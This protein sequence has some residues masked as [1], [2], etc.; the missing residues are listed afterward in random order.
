MA[1]QKALQDLKAPSWQQRLAAARSLVASAGADDLP[2]LLEARATETAKFVQDVL[3]G[4]LRRINR[5]VD[6]ARGSE[7]EE[8]P[9]ALVRQLNSKAIEEVTRTFLHEIEPIVGQ[10]F[11]AASAEVPSFAHSRTKAMLGLL[12]QQLEA[13]A[14]LKTASRV[15]HVEK[16]ALDGWLS[17]LVDATGHPRSDI[18]LV[19]PQNLIVECDPA[20]LRLAVGNGLKNAVEA[21]QTLKPRTDDDDGEPRIVVSWDQSHLECWICIKDEGPGLTGAATEV[22]KA[23]RTTKKGHAGMGLAIALQAMETMG[24]TLELE[25]GAE[26]GTRF[27]VRWFFS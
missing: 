22:V 2:L 5:D 27:Q 3:D 17:E 1:S 25:P 19:G 23:G 8:L 9:P 16:L 21:V 10:I 15:P 26:A 12:K 13:I 4:V 6:E 14:Q 18:A 11:L 20:L 24:G 7:V